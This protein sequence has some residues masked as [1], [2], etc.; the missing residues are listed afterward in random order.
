MRALSQR[1]HSLV[2]VAAT[3][4][5]LEEELSAEEWEVEAPRV[6]VEPENLAYV[7]YT[8]GSTGRPKGV[9]IPHAGLLNLVRWHQELYG[10]TFE[11]HGTQVA[12]PAF[13][14]SIWELWPYLSA[15]A[16]LYIPDALLQ[17][18]DRFQILV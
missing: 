4:L 1:R 8:S 6:R 10:V 18:A 5:C 15:G 3:V 7:V 11:D 9:E 12:S 2:A 16:S 13:D 14:A 17:F